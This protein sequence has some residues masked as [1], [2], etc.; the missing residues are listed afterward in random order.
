VSFA[1]LVLP[2]AVAVASLAALT[3]ARIGTV[4]TP[5]RH[6][7]HDTPPGREPWNTSYQV[8]EAARRAAPSVGK[9]FLVLQRD[10]SARPPARHACRRPR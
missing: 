5:K 8:T 9:L 7:R 4:P 10:K 6:A 1:G 2:F 3:L